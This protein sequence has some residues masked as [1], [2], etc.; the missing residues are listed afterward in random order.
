MPHQLPIPQPKGMNRCRTISHSLNDQQVCIH[1][2]AHHEC[3][4]PTSKIAP[5]APIGFGTPHP[6][7]SSFAASLKDTDQDCWTLTSNTPKP[8]N[9]D[10]PAPNQTLTT[11]PIVA[12]NTESRPYSRT[13]PTSVPK[14]FVLSHVLPCF[15]K[16]TR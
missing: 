12:L 2:P 6:H 10:A 5:P 16:S 11:I 15:V 4:T 1:R 3:F 8:T 13:T 7:Y 9:K 14:M